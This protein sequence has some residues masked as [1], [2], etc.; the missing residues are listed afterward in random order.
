[1]KWICSKDVF[2]MS[3][4]RWFRFFLSV[5]RQK[6]CSSPI[7]SHYLRMLASSETKFLCCVDVVFA[8]V[9]VV[10]VVVAVVVVVMRSRLTS[11]QLSDT[12]CLMNKNTGL[13]VAQ[14]V[15]AVASGTRGVWFESRHRQNFKILLHFIE[16]TWRRGG[17][18]RPVWK[19]GILGSVILHQNKGLFV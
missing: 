14:L 8:V 13:V 6:Q 7:K 19:I 18:E 12:K 11:R 17:R 15:R 4:Q 10:V 3:T 5:P 9:A 1:M 16:N 2:L